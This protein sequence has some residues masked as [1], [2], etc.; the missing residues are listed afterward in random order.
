MKNLLNLFTILLM[1]IAVTSCSGTKS[2]TETTSQTTPITDP[3]AIP[4]NPNLPSSPTGMTSAG[5]QSS[6]DTTN[7]LFPVNEKGELSDASFINLA[8]LAGKKEM[9]LG[10]IAQQRAQSSEVKTFAKMIVD[11]HNKA[12]ADLKALA[13]S[14]QV[15]ISLES[16][17]LRPDQD[18]A[19]AAKQLGALATDKFDRAYLVTMLEDHR[20]AVALFDLG[21]RSKDP[22]VKAYAE[23]YLP[24]MRAHLDAVQKLTK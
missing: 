6:V 11:D 21:T 24:R 15:T 16:D 8:A 12:D 4:D 10:A 23:K 13:T 22:K 14:A 3:Q 19:A 17:T 5:V 2:A 18:Y 1:A 7:A 9:E 20:K